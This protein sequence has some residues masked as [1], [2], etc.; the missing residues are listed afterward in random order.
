MKTASTRD[1]ILN[2]ALKV[3]SQAGFHGCSIPMLAKKAKIATGGLYVHFK[4]KEALV[5]E[6]YVDWKSRFLATL[7]TAASGSGTFEERY[8]RLWNACVDFAG[9]SPEA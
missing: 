2:A 5:N 9:Q 7:S 8:G 1:R 3:F 4:N 6:L